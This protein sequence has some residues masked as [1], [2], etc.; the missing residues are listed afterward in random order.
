MRIQRPMP[1]DLAAQAERLG[2]GWQQQFDRR[3][4][5]ADAVVEPV[6]AVLGVDALDRH[7][8]HQHLDLGDLR[9]I[10]G[11][12][13]FDVVRARRLHHVA[14]PVGGDV[15]AR[16]R[17][18]DRVDLGD[19]DAALERGGL[20][21]HRRILGVRPGVEIAVAVGGLR[22]DQRHARGQIDEVAAEQFQVGMDR[23]D[24]DA[25]VGDQPR[26]AQRLRPGEGKIQALRDAAFEHVQVRRQRQ[27]RLQ[28]V[29]P[30][31]PRR[32]DLGE[33]LREEIGLFLVVAFQAHA[34]ARLDHRLQQRHRVLGLHQAPARQPGGALKAL[35]AV[36]GERVPVLRHKAF[37]RR[38]EGG[39]AWRRGRPKL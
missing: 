38:M 32:I 6:H 23:A 3:G 18:H 31:H 12:Q 4:V 24:L 22:G 39:S 25:L 36:V 29:Q 30:V 34:V 10:A 15:H 9:R 19:D 16:Q 21:D 5:E 35:P 8:R 26:Q 7:H 33:A 1:A 17:V 13:R 27:H 20:G 11:E 28:Q 14:D 2:I 37:R